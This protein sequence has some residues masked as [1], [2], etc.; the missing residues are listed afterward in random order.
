MQA[1]NNA[2]EQRPLK[3]IL[4]ATFRAP[5]HYALLLLESLPAADQERFASLAQDEDFYGLL[6]PRPGS[7][8]GLKAVDCETALLFYTLQEP[9]PIPRYVR[10]RFG[11]EC[12]AA[13][14]TLVLDGVLEIAAAGG[15]DF[16]SGADAYDRLYARP[17]VA[18]AAQGAIGRLSRAALLYAQTIALSSRPAL[19]ARLYQYNTVPASPRWRRQLPGRA[20]VE[21][22]LGLEAGG[23]A[24][25]ALAPHWTA[26]EGVDDDSWIAWQRR[27]PA[28]AGPTRYKL[29]VSPAPDAL[30]SVW[31][32]LLAAL[33]A[34]PAQAFKV[35]A[36]VHG[37]L[38]PDKIVAY[39]PSF[40]AL[41]EAA[42]RLREALGACPAQGVPFT[43]AVDP[44][45]LLSWGM[46]PPADAGFF[47][48]QGRESWRLWIANRLAVALLDARAHGA[49]LPPWR[50]AVERLRLEGVDTDT[51]TPR[52]TMWHEHRSI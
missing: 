3:D 5:P 9:G 13:I 25:A 32:P 26:A 39:F 4:D 31:L 40:E 2:G 43:A 46:D 27:R 38:R 21:R 29:Y 42:D 24:R 50:F 15:E 20:A 10:R 14:A 48:W 11:P 33:S 7:G 6:S 35:G 44:A 45:G 36:T 8:L 28:A 23:S 18:E 22:F 41:A 1:A 17:L 30:P 12:N 19:S 37:L 52:Q 49:E 16:V 34:G 51:W 47:G